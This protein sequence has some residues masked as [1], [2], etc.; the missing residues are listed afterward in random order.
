MRIALGLP[1]KVTASGIPDR[2]TLRSLAGCD[3]GFDK[4]PMPPYS[5]IPSPPTG[6]NMDAGR[7]N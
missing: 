5:R 1:G 7:R 4:R 6:S 2:T 3:S